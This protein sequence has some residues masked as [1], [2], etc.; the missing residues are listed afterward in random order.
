[1]VKEIH[2]TDY[3]TGMPK[4]ES[5][6]TVEITV[7]ELKE[8]E[9]LV[10]NNW[11]SVDPYMRGRMINRK[12]YIPPFKLN[13]ALEGSA[14]GTVQASKHK[15]FMP[16]DIVI[17]MKGWREQFI[18]KDRELVKLPDTSSPEHYLGL[19]GMPGLTAYS[20]L[21]KIGQPKWG[22]TV[23]VSAAS[24]AVGSL[25][26]QIAKIK[27]CKVIA[28]AG[29]DEKVKWLKEEI[30]VDAAFNYKKYNDLNVALKEVTPNGIDIYFDNVGG[31]HLEAAINQMNTHGRIVVCGM[32]SQYNLD[33]PV[34]GPDNL[35]Q[36]ISKRLL[37]QGFIV[38]DYDKVKPEFYKDM[39][40]WINNGDIKYETHIYYGIENASKAFINL[41]RGENLGKM[42][43][44]L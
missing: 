26:C 30:K 8:G 15:D 44:K 43:V 12:S 19:L 7:P 20:G 34:P 33:K 6:K 36:I 27:G 9:V 39:Q 16:G 22:E 13:E 14:V 42:L 24:G 32:I 1:M 18:A 35:I 28:S 10:K 5:F 37:M 40:Q 17:S 41:F 11:M 38:S 2:I 3:V 23:F 31:D 21:L 29:S 4:T 25:V